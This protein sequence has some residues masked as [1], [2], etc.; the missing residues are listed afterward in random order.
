MRWASAFVNADYIARGLSGP[1]ASA[2]AIEA[3]CIMLKRLRQLAAGAEDFAFESTLSSRSFAHFLSGLRAEGYRVVIFYFSLSSAWLAVRRV[4]LR[5]RLGGH[6]VPEDDVRRRYD[7][8]LKNFFDLYLP[9]A[10]EW[11][12]F[13][14]SEHG[15]ASLVASQGAGGL[16]VKDSIRWQRLLQ[17]SR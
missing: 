17:H 15:R 4:R 11:S 10:D 9:L 2:V 8:S 5:V 1:R 13:D 14:N 7:R 16:I 12:L 3:G 6:D